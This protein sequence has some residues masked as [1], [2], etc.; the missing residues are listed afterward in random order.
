MV[1]LRWKVVQKHTVTHSHTHTRSHTHTHP[2]D[3]RKIN[4]SCTEL[5]QHDHLI[6]RSKKVTINKSVTRLIIQHDCQGYQ[7]TFKLRFL[8]SV[9]G[10]I[11]I[12]VKEFIWCWIF[13]IVSDANSQEPREIQFPFPPGL[14]ASTVHESWLRQG[15]H[16]LSCVYLE[17]P[18]GNQTESGKMSLSSGRH[19]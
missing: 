16:A 19:V 6:T 12:M 15:G 2:A 13:R 14:T 17:L 10:L 8:L 18:I 5:L 11:L 7:T 4:Q 3:W 1:I 9:G